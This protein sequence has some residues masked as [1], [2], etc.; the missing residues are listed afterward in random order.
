M[1]LGSAVE[2]LLPVVG[3]GE[4]ETAAPAAAPGDPDLL[5]LLAGSQL[6]DALLPGAHSLLLLEDEEGDA[7]SEEDQ[8]DGQEAPGDDADMRGVGG[9]E[10]GGA[11]D[12]ESEVTGGGVEDLSLVTLH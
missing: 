8:E 7:H 1:N 12:P 2:L 6:A 10:R 9:E 4:S 11:G 3:G 5:H